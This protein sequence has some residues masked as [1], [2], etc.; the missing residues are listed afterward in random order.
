EDQHQTFALLQASHR[1]ADDRALSFRVIGDL[2]RA[3]SHSWSWR[4]RSANRGRP[5]AGGAQS[6]RFVDSKNLIVGA[7]TQQDN[8]AA[9]SVGCY[10]SPRNRAIWTGATA[11]PGV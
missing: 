2:H 1:L 6:T 9:C 7:G 11:G 10:D 3:A 5:S 4:H 8:I